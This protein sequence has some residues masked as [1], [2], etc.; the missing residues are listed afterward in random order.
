MNLFDL[1]RIEAELERTN[2]EIEQEDFWNNLEYA[3]KVMREKK[4]MEDTLA[5]YHGL[6][7][8]LDD[9]AELIELAEM[10]EEAGAS[11]EDLE[12]IDE[13]SS[14]RRCGKLRIA[15]AAEHDGIHQIDAHGN[16]RLQRNRNRNHEYLG[17]EFARSQIFFPTV[18]RRFVPH[19]GT[20]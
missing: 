9:V 20:G 14:Q 7:K 15:H 18:H 19:R 2:R 3:Q 8:S 16:Q 12:Q 1:A 11:A 5:E 13:L 4:G 10:E 17:V 6:E